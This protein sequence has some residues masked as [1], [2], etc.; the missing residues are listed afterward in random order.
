VD[1]AKVEAVS[2][3][4]IPKSVAEIRSFLGLARYY[5]RF[6]K[7]FSKI[8]RSLTKLTRKG[9]NFIWSDVCQEVF[10]ELKLRLTTAPILTV[11]DE[12]GGLVILSDAT[13]RGLGYVL[14]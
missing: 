12:L 13:G 6:V 5:K 14:M 9:K 3:W 7:D 4:P 8:V 1:P 10:E 11:P 2:D